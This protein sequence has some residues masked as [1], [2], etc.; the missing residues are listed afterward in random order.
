M[1]KVVIA[2]IA[3]SSLDFVL[4]KRIKGLIDREIYR[5][6]LNPVA[7]SR[8]LCGPLKGLRLIRLEGDWCRI[9]FRITETEVQ[10]VSIKLDSAKEKKQQDFLE[11]ARTLF[12]QRLI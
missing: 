4:N 8:L 1:R 6:A 12:R 5:L 7:E 9:I 11:L 10:I 3:R 2:P